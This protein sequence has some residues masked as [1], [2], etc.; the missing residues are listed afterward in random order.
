MS[1]LPG[2]RVSESD[3]CGGAI[4]AFVRGGRWNADFAAVGG[5]VLVDGVCGVLFCVCRGISGGTAV[6]FAAAVEEA[7]CGGR[8][9][10]FADLVS[11]LVL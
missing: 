7:G 9:G 8:V 4:L 2:Q 3:V 11:V 1:A 5:R 6:D 10:S